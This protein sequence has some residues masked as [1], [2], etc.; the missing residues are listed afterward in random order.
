MK[1]LIFSFLCFSTFQS[2]GQADSS[3]VGTV[4]VIKD[5]RIDILGRKMADYNGSIVAGVRNAKG[6][7]L[8]L[9]STSDRNA[10]MQLRSILLQQY[11]DQKVYMTFQSP[12]IKLKFGNFLERADAE[13]FR[14]QIA[15]QNLVNGN[16]Y[17]LPGMIE[18][19][20]EK[21]Q[22]PDL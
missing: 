14:K 18:V 19:K 6:Y 22:D 4:I 20:P 9:L 1:Q 11:P 7:R 21:L 13:K 16:I 12:Y 8:M 5:Y 17:I 3:I 10:A 2:F 15:S